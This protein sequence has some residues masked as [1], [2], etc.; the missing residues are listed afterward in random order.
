MQAVGEDMKLRVAPGNKAAIKPNKTVALIEG[1]KRHG[2]LRES[3]VNRR[4]KGP[5][6]QRH[7]C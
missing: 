6:G 2:K 1:R 5:S 3:G 7:A 4:M